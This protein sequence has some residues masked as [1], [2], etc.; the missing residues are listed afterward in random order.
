MH[1]V[2]APAMVPAGTVF[3]LVARR[4]LSDLVRTRR[5]LLVAAI[6][7]IPI[8]VTFFLRQTADDFVSTS[9]LLSGI[10]SLYASF[11]IYFVAMA[12]GVPTIHD[13]VE[14]RTITYLLTRPVS[15]IAVFAGRLFAVQ[16][17]VG[18]LLALSLVGSF[19]VL[20]VGNF[21]VL[22]ADLVRQYVGHVWVVM[23]ATMVFTGLFAVFGLLFKKP[24]PWCAAYAFAW[25]G[26]V[27][28]IPG[29][30]Q[31]YTLEFHVRNVML[32]EDDVQRSLWDMIQGLVVQS[33]DVSPMA[34]LG[35]LFGAL[36]VFSVLGGWIF[37]G[38]E[39]VIN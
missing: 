12:F 5:L 13:E 4:A 32:R 23:L 20:V 7:L 25:E 6:G 11:L 19:A 33:P 39:Y 36:V 26:T 30:M 14:G 31:L 8:L 27:S 1:A 22:N 9:A 21:G 17:T 10:A 15:R 16:L 34:S 2:S 38:R 3:A 35:V 29:S 28:K 37:R 18:A 24:L